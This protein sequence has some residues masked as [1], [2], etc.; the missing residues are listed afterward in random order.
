VT[1]E[2]TP[3]AEPEEIPGLDMKTKFNFLMVSQMGPRK[4]FSNA[5][6]WWIEEFIIMFLTNGLCLRHLYYQMH[7]NQIVK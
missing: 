7:L 1:W 5:I 3:Q 6:G 2:S 4:N